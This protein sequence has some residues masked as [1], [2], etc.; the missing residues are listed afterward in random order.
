DAGKL[1]AVT[2]FDVV[3]DLDVIVICVPTPLDKNL[4]PDLSYVE[5]VTREVGKRL[6]PGQLVTLESTTYPGTTDEL[7]RPILETSS[8]LKQ[9]NDFFLAHSPE[10]VDP[11]NQRYTTKN[12]NKVV[13][14]SDPASLEVATA[15]YR[16]TIE[17]VV[18]V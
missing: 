18:P 4:T 12:T 1:K 5:G 16:K 2:G 6:R 7:M 17:H 9:G 8:G 11:G 14:A 15:F 10:R 3:P 13:G